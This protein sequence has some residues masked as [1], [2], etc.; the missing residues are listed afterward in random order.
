MRKKRKKRLL[1][2]LLL[3]PSFVLFVMFYYYP[4]GKTI[5][6][7]FSITTEIGQFIK[8]AGLAN[9]QRLF[10]SSDFGIIFRNTFKFAGLNLVMT[11]LGAMILALLCANQGKCSRLYQTL[12]ALPMVI[13]S[14][15]IA[16]MWRFIYRGDAGLLNSLLGTDRAWLNSPDTAMVALAVVVSWGHIASCFLYLL[17]GFRNVS[18]DLIEAATIDGAGKWTRAVK[19]MI[20]I[21]SPQLFFVLFT[22]IISAFKTFT[23][24]K[25]LT[26][27]GPAGSTTTLMYEVYD[28]AMNRGQMEAACCYALVLFVV[29][30]IATRIQFL[31]EKKLVHYQ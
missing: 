24:I 28:R 6:T 11:F 2:Y 27:G 17:V 3:L 14:A 22:S 13:A 9:W 19:I 15:P 4:F 29:I 20:P 21:A 23:Q 7:S 30:F 26:Y 25:L 8:W 18:E 12:Y 31:F 16:A 5:V 1:P 10:Q